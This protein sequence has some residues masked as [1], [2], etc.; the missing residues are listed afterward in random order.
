[1]KNKGI[2]PK[3][4]TCETSARPAASELS[5]PYAAGTNTDVKPVG[6]VAT[7]SAHLK[8][9]SLINRLVGSKFNRAIIPSII[10]G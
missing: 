9:T 8:K 2:L 4:K 3:E 10:K 7:Q 6:I 5:F 1:M